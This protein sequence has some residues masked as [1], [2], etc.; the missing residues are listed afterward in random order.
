MMIDDTDQLDNLTDDQLWEVAADTHN[1]P[2]IRQEAIR[3]WL[4]PEDIDPDADPD[5]LDGGRLR[6]LRM[7]AS[8]LDSDEVEEDEDEI[9][10]IEEMAPYF[11]T[12]G[13]L[14]LRHDGVS[15]LIETLDDEGAYDGIQVKDDKYTND[16]KTNP[17]RDL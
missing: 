9:E 1:T 7:R 10:D 16:D 14:I 13:R 17:D 4:F 5:D 2:E 15:Y 3:L 6:E 12:Q 8:V 11:D